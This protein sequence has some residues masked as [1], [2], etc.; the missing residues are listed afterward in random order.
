MNRSLPQP[1]E[2][3]E[4]PADGYGAGFIE[5]RIRTEFRDLCRLIGKEA[6][7]QEIAHIVNDEFEGKRQ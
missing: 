7:R 1:V 6:A 2:S 4:T 3:R 5:Y